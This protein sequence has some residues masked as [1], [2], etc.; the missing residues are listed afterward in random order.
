MKRSLILIFC[1]LLALWAP[2]GAE[3]PANT[4]ALAGMV[5]KEPGDQ[6]LKKVLLHLITEDQKQGSNY[7][8]DTDSEGRFRIEKIQPGRYRLL[9]EKSG[10]HQI[11][12]RGHQAEG[13][14]LSVQA[15]QEINDLL[16]QMLPSAVITGRVVDEDGDP[17]PGYGVSLLRK[18]PGKSREPE[19]VGEERTND[20][21]EYRF[22]SLFPGQY[23]VAVVPLPDIRNFVHSRDSPD[24]PSKPDLAYL[25][26]YY[27][28]T[29]D[30]AQAGAIDLHAG[31]EMPVNFALVPARSYR[32]R[33]IVT[34]IPAN[35]KP[36]VQL[37]SKGVSQTMNGADVSADGQFEIRGVAPGLYFI[38]AFAG[39][40]GQILSA[41]QS[42]TVLAADVEGVKLIPVRPFTLSGHL[43]FEGQ[44]PK[45]IA[46]YTVSLRGTDDASGSI[47][48]VPG[49][50][51]GAGV[52]RFG[53][54]SWTD[55]NPGSYAVQVDD[56]EHPES[57]FLKS[58]TL[59]NSN[60]DAGFS[61][62]GPATVELVVSS[63]AGMLE[64][65]AL[66]KDKPA[67][68]A[69]VVAVPEEKYRKLHERFG[70]GSTDQNGRFAIHGLA[71][72]GYTVFAWQD[73]DDGLYYDAGFLK[74]QESNGASL[75]V[76]EGSRQKIELKLSMVSEEWQ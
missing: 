22:S 52:D 6:P 12:V 13:P 19:L 9:L 7:T 44:P 5:V 26:T 67:S 16:F 47:Y 70:V 76:E 14:I 15:G 68:N 20:L 60:A 10:F 29:S 18:R 56:R 41:R 57:G 36:M 61:V 74:S 30:A 72:G 23:L 45:D 62:T 25:T 54:F 17:L 32:I 39:A 34:G 28:G 50:I 2:A 3:E 4:A 69:T 63:K 31:D 65:V 35:Q 64:G 37:I 1:L 55:V 42:V 40:E 66:D 38:T 8:A 75:K 73:L 59:G 46:Q 71:P 27:P 24:T 53:N 51:S 21:G 58:V 33:G 43:R 48:V 49:G 11:N